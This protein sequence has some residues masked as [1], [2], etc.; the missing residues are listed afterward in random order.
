MIKQVKVT[1]VWSEKESHSDEVPATKMFDESYMEMLLDF[2]KMGAKILIEKI[3][4]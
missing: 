3:E 4:E 1:A 2:V